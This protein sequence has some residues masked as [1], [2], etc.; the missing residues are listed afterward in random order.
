MVHLAS[1]V[2]MEI[3]RNYENKCKEYVLFWYFSS[4]RIESPILAMKHHLN[5][6][7]Q[8]KMKVMLCLLLPLWIALIHSSCSKDKNDHGSFGNLVT[9]VVLAPDGLTPIAGATTA[10]SAPRQYPYLSSGQLL[11]LLG[12]LKGAA[13][14]ETLVERKD[15]ATAG[16]DSQSIAHVIIVIF[17]IVGNI[18][19]IRERRKKP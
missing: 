19:L 16:M 9:G 17:I 13:E 11:G 4:V 8:V 3:A 7:W 12:G 6:C 14:Y 2:C 15:R 5:L 1:C 18:I 10:I